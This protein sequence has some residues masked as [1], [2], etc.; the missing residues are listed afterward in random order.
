M[1]AFE[2]IRGPRRGMRTAFARAAALLVCLV[3]L[4]APRALRSSDTEL[5]GRGSSPSL[6]PVTT[7]DGLDLLWIVFRPQTE[8]LRSPGLV[9][10]RGAGPRTAGDY[11]AGRR[12]LLGAG[13]I[14]G[15]PVTCLAW[16]VTGRR[17]A[18]SAWV[19][20]RTS[21]QAPP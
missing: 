5:A 19:S 16:A 13:C 4:A 2:V 15:P 7:S 1:G 9:Q 20:T 21:K 18:T 14:V 17:R 3:S 6:S 12:R 10:V 8:A 11:A